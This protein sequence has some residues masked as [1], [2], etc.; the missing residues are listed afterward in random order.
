MTT[1]TYTETGII[2]E[3]HAADPV[4]CHGISAITQMVANYVS[5]NEW[6]TVTL[7]DGYLEINN[8]KEQYCGNDL[9]KAMSRAIRDIAEN[10]PGNVEIKHRY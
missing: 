8:V 2:V 7:S 4:V 6:G 1:I 10:Y 9:F 3:G 5:D